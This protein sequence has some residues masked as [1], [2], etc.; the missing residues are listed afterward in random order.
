MS[1]YV[2]WQE[3][4]IPVRLRSCPACGYHNRLAQPSPYSVRP[5]TLKECKV[6][7]LVYVHEA[8][9]YD[10]LEKNLAWEKSFAHETRRREIETPKTFRLSRAT[11]WR[12]RL[13]PRRNVVD[14][15]VR[16]ALPG[17]VIDLGC[18]SGGLGQSYPAGFV[19]YGIEI[20]PSLAQGAR[21]VFRARGGDVVQAPCAEGLKAFPDEFFNG[22]TLRSYL[23][24]EAEPRTVME[25]LRRVL[26]P[27][28]PAVVKVPNFA[29][30]NRVIRGRN[31]C[32]FRFPEHLNHFTPDALRRLARRAG[33]RYDAGWLDR[34]PTSDNMYAILT[35]V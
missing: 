33:F 24:H 1:D 26:K 8:P 10:A 30:W 3:E 32:G 7:A 22:A 35:R 19:P 20:S 9:V 29:S 16:H 11:R 12:M 5:W 4:E 15:L 13:L 34:L 31:W 23:E 21:T 28:A 18:G 25:E 27:G 14:M 2:I 17:P 6:C